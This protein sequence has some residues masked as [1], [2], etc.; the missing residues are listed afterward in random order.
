MNLLERVKSIDR[1]IEVITDWLGE[2]GETVSQEL[3]Q[4]RALICM[5]CPMNRP[6]SM[7]VEAVASAIRRHIEVKNDLGVR[8]SGEENL[9]ECAICLCC[10]KLKVHVPI[11]VIRRHMFEN[12]EEKFLEANAECWQVNE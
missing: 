12:E 8:V 9:H 11:E 3:A 1:G 7:M 4:K 5:Q 10:L 2:G 6:G